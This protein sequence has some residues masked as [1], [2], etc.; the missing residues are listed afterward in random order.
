VPNPQFY[1][2]LGQHVEGLPCASGFYC[3]PLCTQVQL[4]VLQQVLVRVL[5]WLLVL[6]VSMLNGRP[7]T[8]I[9]VTL[10]MYMLLLLVVT[11]SYISGGCSTAVDGLLLCS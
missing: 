2:Q 10:R 7:A 3:Q 6:S 1:L 4:L 11:S 9:Q 8:I 5:A